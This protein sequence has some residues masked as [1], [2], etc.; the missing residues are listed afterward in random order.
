[1][2]SNL[3]LSAK[4]AGDRILSGAPILEGT[5]ITDTLHLEGKTIKGD[6]NLIGV[7]FEHLVFKNMKLDSLDLSGSTFKSGLGFTK[8]S[9]NDYLCL[10]KIMT[11]SSLTIEG[12][13][14]EGFLNLNYSLIGSFMHFFETSVLGN[15]FFAFKKGP[16]YILVNERMAQLIHWSAPNVPLVVIKGEIDKI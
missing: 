11:G 7:N 15:I 6:V 2:K 12:T 8:V 10:E 14:I 13:T 4:E 16:A 5:T 1:M 3:T 9:F